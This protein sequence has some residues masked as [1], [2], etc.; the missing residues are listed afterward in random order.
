MFFLFCTCQLP[1]QFA[2]LGGEFEDAGGKHESEQQPL[3]HPKNDRVFRRRFLGTSWRQR[4]HQNAQDARFQQ[5]FVP[6]IC[7]QK[8]GW[9][10]MWLNLPLLCHEH[11]VDLEERQVEKPQDRIHWSN[12]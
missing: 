2:A 12:A 5:Q 7:H 3:D 10:S 1:P 11:W 9:T 6:K 8:E 4:S